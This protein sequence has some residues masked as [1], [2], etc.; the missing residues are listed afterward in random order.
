[1]RQTQNVDSNER[2]GIRP[3]GFNQSSVVC[4]KMFS[5][6]MIKITESRYPLNSF[7]STPTFYN[8]NNPLLTELDE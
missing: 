2:K 3:K 1:M 8:F 7:E 5:L 6:D 4:M